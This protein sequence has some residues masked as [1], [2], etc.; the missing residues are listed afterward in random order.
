[1]QRFLIVLA[2]G[3]VFSGCATGP[4]YHNPQGAAAGAAAGYN[5]GAALSQ[6]INNSVAE[7][8]RAN[9]K[10][11]DDYNR[12]MRQLQQDELMRQQTEYYRQQNELQRQQ[13][14]NLFPDR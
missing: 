13:Q 6:S 9:Q 2:V 11:V 10:I 12:N 14:Y 4:Y 3:A 7:T 1:M 8:Q 5:W